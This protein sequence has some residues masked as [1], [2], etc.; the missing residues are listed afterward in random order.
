MR[1]CALIVGDEPDAP[2]EQSAERRIRQRG[3]L[4]LASVAQFPKQTPARFADLNRS[5]MRALS[6]EILLYIRADVFSQNLGRDLWLVPLRVGRP[7]NPIVQTLL[8]A[9]GTDGLE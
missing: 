2:A 9:F 1:R 7:A 5:W 8:V 6:P 4:R 3:Q